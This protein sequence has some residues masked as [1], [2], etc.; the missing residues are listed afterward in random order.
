MQIACNNSLPQVSK[1]NNYT[2][3]NVDEYPRAVLLAKF[4]PFDC[5]LLPVSFWR[6][7][8]NMFIVTRMQSEMGEASLTL[9]RKPK[10]ADC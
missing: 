6:R 9:G 10:Q 8:F 5:C 2:N 3:K 1:S 7:S 4:R